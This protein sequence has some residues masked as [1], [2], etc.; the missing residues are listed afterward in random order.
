[1]TDDRSELAR[2]HAVAEQEND[3]I[4]SGD[5]E[6]YWA[7]LADDCVMMPPNVP[8]KTGPELRRWLREFLETVAVASLGF[9]HGGGAIAGG[10]AWHEYA[11]DWRVTPRAGGPATTPRFKGL[12]IL[13]RAP[14]GSWKIVRNIWNLNPP[15]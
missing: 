10:W 12:H 3:A 7:I 2:I 9:E 15:R 4:I 1:M 14:D 8:P 6:R 13:R 5:L 11:C